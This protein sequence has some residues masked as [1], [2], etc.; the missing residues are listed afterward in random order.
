MP[1][2]FHYQ[3]FSGM[4][5]PYCNTV[6]VDFLNL[7]GPLNPWLRS[8]PQ[9]MTWLWF[10]PDFCSLLP[11]GNRSGAIKM[12]SID[13]CI[14]GLAAVEWEKQALDIKR[15][16]SVRVGGVHHSNQWNLLSRIA[17]Y[18]RFWYW[19][20]GRVPGYCLF[21][22]CTINSVLV[23]IAAGTRGQCVSLLAP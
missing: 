19:A 17:A 14:R 4:I 23:L 22:G 12:S 1:L 5:H 3:A 13:C 21:D 18:D 7:R 15:W 20:T 8:S 6:H 9:K 16:A 10:T 2:T 11:L